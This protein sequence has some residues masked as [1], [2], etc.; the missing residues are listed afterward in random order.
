MKRKLALLFII[1]IMFISCATLPSVGFCIKETCIMTHEHGAKV[2]HDG[3]EYECTFELAP[4]Q[5]PLIKI[6]FDLLQT[7]G[8]M[9]VT[10]D[11]KK[12]GCRIQ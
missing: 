5:A 8:E 11:G 10:V 9:Y 1:P 2:L 4:E 3:K 7:T 12:I 6:D